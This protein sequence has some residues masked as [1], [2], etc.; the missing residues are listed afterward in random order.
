MKNKNLPVVKTYELRNKNKIP[1]VMT[2]NPKQIVSKIKKIK[3][4]AKSKKATLQRK[5]AKKLASKAS[6]KNKNE[7]IK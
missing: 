7:K 6:I 3:K 1:K 4:S 5:V 2:M